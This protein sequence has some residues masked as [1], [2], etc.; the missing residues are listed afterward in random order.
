M[1]KIILRTAL[2][3]ANSA[4]LCDSSND[5]EGAIDAY[6]EAIALLDRVLETV[7]KESDRRRLQE[8]VSSLSGR[9]VIGE[10]A[11]KFMA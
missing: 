5:V 11:S 7:E 1:S 3:K 9:V 6:S 8:I 4:V 10:S 2:E